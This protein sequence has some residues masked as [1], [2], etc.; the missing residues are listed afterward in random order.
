LTQ[1][2]LYIENQNMLEQQ[3]KIL[4]FFNCF[5]A[6]AILRHSTVVFFASI[7]RAFYY[8][9][10]SKYSKNRLHNFIKKIKG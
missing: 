9:M 4:H 7:F 2:I 5:D 1:Y 8:I 3:I 10:T 6:K